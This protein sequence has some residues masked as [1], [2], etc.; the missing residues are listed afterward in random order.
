MS[1]KI[2]ELKEMR[3]KAVADGRV[4]L[5]K[6]AAEK[7]SMN[8]EEKVQYE[9]FIS[10]ATRIGEDIATEE[11]QLSLEKEMLG[12]KLAQKEEKRGNEN[13]AEEKRMAAFRKLITEGQTN[14]NAE[15]VRALTAGTDTQGGFLLAP[16]E[17]I[18]ELIAAVKN[19]VFMRGLARII[20]LN[21]AASCGVPSL[22]TDVGDADWTAEVKTV[23]ED[24]SLAFGKREL[25]P[26]PLSKLV[27]V[28][29]KLLRNAALNPESIV[30]DRMAY[31]FGV[32]MEKGYLVGTGVQQPL[33]VFT[34][35]ADGISTARD[36][37]M[38]T[39]NT[40]TITSDGLIASKYALKAQYL[41]NSRWIFHRDALKQIVQLKTGDG[42]YIFEL[43][44][45]ADV[46]DTLLGRPLLMSEFA[47]NTFTASSYVGI[48]G[49]F[50]NYWIADSLALQFMRLNELFSLSNQVGFIG[51]METDGMPVLGE[52]FARVQLS[53]A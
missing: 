19:Q 12:L 16:Q 34:A 43:S 38:A 31:K 21:S 49:D 47:P 32:S 53:A 9:S 30:M 20:P 37:A 40:T 11:R 13:P 17:F 23:A 44:D 3:G 52:A 48:I 45:K 51:R 50:S 42:Y 1:K 26:H 18:A 25:M 28:S 14:L 7:R 5:D 41:Q 46:P 27:K 33:G 2:A 15:E 22:D 39:G 35:S 24:T 10:D 29:N 6:A 4:I 8:A 36:I